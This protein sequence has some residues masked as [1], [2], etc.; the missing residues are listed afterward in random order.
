[1]SASVTGDWRAS[2][3]RC[4]DLPGQRL[5]QYETEDGWQAVLSEDVNGY[6]QSVLGEEF[7]AKDFRTWHGTLVAF[8]ALSG[9]TAS[10]DP[11]QRQAAVRAAVD[12]VADKLGN[13]RAVARSAYVHPALDR[14]FATGRLPTGSFAARSRW[15]R[16]GETELLR[17]LGPRR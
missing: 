13:T 10:D 6:I 4:Q 14:A 7:S 17:L 11:R 12:L 15:R 9:E 16:P 1:M 2:I 5:F 8:E 3:R